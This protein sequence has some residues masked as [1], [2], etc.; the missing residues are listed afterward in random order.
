MSG[1]TKNLGEPGPT[2]FKTDAKAIEF[3]SEI[4]KLWL[5]KWM[6]FTNS[7][8]KKS[9]GDKWK[10]I[11]IQEAAAFVSILIT[12]SIMKLPQVNLDRVNLAIVNTMQC[13]IV[14]CISGIILL[15]PPRIQTP[16][17]VPIDA[18]CAV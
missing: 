14:M 6:D 7:Y 17:G 12:M 2:N 9:K 5:L 8:A 10:G 16:R 18:I 11:S 4:G 15:E 3:F 13:C 1:T